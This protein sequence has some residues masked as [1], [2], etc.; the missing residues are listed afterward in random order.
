MPSAY[1]VVCSGLVSAGVADSPFQYADIVTTT[2]HKSLRGPRAGMIFY[3]KGPIPEDRLPKGVPAGTTYDYEGKIDFAVF[4]S[5]QGGPHNHQIAALAVALKHAASD[6]FKAYQKQVGSEFSTCPK[7]LALVR[8]IRTRKTIHHD[9]DIV[10]LLMR[11]AIQE[12]EVLCRV[13]ENDCICSKNGYTLWQV[14]L[15]SRAWVIRTVWGITESQAVRS[16]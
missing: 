8:T 3:R 16:L 1:V 13:N 7:V 6:E 11:A 5:L 2:T 10:S 14:Q 12:N 15:P 4:P 9:I